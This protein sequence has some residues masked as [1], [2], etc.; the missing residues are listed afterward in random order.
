MNSFEPVSIGKPSRV[1]DS[2]QIICY[3]FRADR[4]RELT[5]ALALES[6]SGFRAPRGF[7]KVGYV[8]MTEYERSLNLATAFGP[9]D[10]PQHAGRGF[11]ARENPQ[12]PH[13][14]DRE[15]RARDLLPQ[16]RRREAIS[17]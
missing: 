7:R 14:G 12:H 3:N 6:F 17:I 5:S 8:C 13:R 10:I 11:R 2:D 15:V 4:A 16:R 1:S 9:E